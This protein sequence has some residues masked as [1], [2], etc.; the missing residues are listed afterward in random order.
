MNRDRGHL[1]ERVIFWLGIP[2]LGVPFLGFAIV[3]Q[4]PLP[5]HEEDLTASLLNALD[6]AAALWL[7]VLLSSSLAI[8]LSVF[9]QRRKPFWHR[10]LPRS[11]AV[12]QLILFGLIVIWV[13][14]QW[15][16]VTIFDRSPVAYVLIWAEAAAL[17]ALPIVIAVKA[18]NLASWEIPALKP[19]STQRDWD[20]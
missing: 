13:I 1:F 3:T 6:P 20:E 18:G 19:A 7:A 16:T 17:G 15:L 9:A 12:L 2:F 14:T 8:N 11:V 4:F 5:T 10:P